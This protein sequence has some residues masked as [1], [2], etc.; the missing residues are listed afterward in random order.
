MGNEIKRFIC[1]KEI[2]WDKSKGEYAIHPDAVY[3][4]DK[5]YGDGDYSEVYECPNCGLRFESTIGQ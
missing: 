2:P 5:D 4:K 3:I 1:T